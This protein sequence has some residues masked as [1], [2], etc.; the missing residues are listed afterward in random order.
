MTMRPPREAH[1]LRNLLHRPDNQPRETAG[2]SGRSVAPSSCDFRHVELG[3]HEQRELERPANGQ[4][5]LFCKDQLADALPVVAQG[6][7]VQAVARAPLLSSPG[8]ARTAKLCN[9]SVNSLS[10]S[11]AP[12]WWRRSMQT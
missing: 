1:Y 12:S 6:E 5:I 4:H 9:L 2:C 7:C 8:V 10:C 3:I 11:F